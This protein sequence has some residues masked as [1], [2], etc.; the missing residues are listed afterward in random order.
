V[1]R[2][3]L[4]FIFVQ[5]LVVQEYTTWRFEDFGFPMVLV[6]NGFNGN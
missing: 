4:Y 5:A 3:S 6:Q 2:K 1:K